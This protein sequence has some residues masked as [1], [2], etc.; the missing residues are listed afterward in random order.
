M[1]SQLAKLIKGD[2]FQI[3]KSIST[4]HLL[5]ICMSYLIRLLRGL[6]YFK[7]T[8]FISKNV[9]LEC[10][11]KISLGKF[12]KI[13]EGCMLSGLSMNGIKTGKYC[14]I[15]AYSRVICSGSLSKLGHGIEIGD[16]FGV[17]E[18]SYLG[19]SGGIKI[20]NNVIMG[21]YVS[22]HSENHNYGDKDVPIKMQGVN[23]I[24]IVLEDDIWIGSKVTILDGAILR[25][26]TIVAAGSVVKG[27]F[28]P[29]V[30]IGGVPAKILKEI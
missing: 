1:I 5:N 12:S 14:S 8:V 30:I 4:R 7:K 3:D 2:D 19:C 6:I 10:R 23:H 28:P 11:E 16:N 22:F 25:K 13:S 17:G 20:G 29:N 27:Q 15:G 21:Q 26:R 24:G 9:S 18:F